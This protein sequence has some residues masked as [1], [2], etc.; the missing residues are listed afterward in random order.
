MRGTGGGG[1]GMLHARRSHYP[2]LLAAV[3]HA[4][5]AEDNARVLDANLDALFRECLDNVLR[6]EIIRAFSEDIIDDVVLRRELLLLRS[7][8]LLGGGLLALGLGSNGF[9]LDL[10]PLLLEGWGVPSPSP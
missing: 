2:K 9:S 1:A 10:L 8:L 4:M 6:L 5:L 7:G 3:V